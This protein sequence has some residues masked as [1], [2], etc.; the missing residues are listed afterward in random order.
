[1]PSSALNCATFKPTKECSKPKWCN[2]VQE[3]FWSSGL[4]AMAVKEEEEE[5]DDETWVMSRALST[6]RHTFVVK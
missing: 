3:I 5:E 1:M 2:M 4:C 6:C